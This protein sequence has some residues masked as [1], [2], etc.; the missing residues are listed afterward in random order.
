MV[1]VRDGG[2]PGILCTSNGGK[3]VMALRCTSE[4]EKMFDGLDM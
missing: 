3:K 2:Y 1:Q 4:V